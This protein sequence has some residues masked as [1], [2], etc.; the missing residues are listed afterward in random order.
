LSEKK[1]VLKAAGLVGLI[2]LVSRCTGLIRDM[3][4]GFKLSA[5]AISDTFWIAFELPNMVR[6]VM[7]EGALSSFLV[8]LFT[9]RRKKS[10]AEG[11]LFFNRVAN[12][13]LVL[14]LALTLFGGV[15]A[16]EAF[17]VFGAW[18]EVWRDKAEA[19]EVE[20]VQPPPSSSDAAANAPAAAPDEKPVLTTEEKIELGTRL[21][22]LMFP[23]VIGLT[24]ASVMMGAC[25]TLGRFATASLGSVMLNLTM[26]AAVAVAIIRGTDLERTT[27]WLC[28]AVLAGAVLRVLLMAPTLWRAG[29]RWRPVL[30]LS[31]PELRKLLKMMGLGL[32]GLSISQINILVGNFFAFYLGDGIKTYLV[33]ANRLV[34]F[35]MALTATAVATAMLPQLSRYIVGG[36]TGELREMMGFTKRVEII[37]MMPAMF[38]LAILGLPIMELLFQH[39]EWTA[40]ASHGAYL[41]LAFYAPALIPLGWIRLLIP[42]CYARKDLI[43]PLKA[44]LVSMVANVILNWFFVFHTPMAQSGLALAFTLASFIQYGWLAWM[45]RADLARRPGEELRIGETVWKSGLA[46]AVSCAVGGVIYFGS[47]RWILAPTNTL[48]RL[49]LFVPSMAAVVLL[50]FALIRQLRAPDFAWVSEQVLNR[51]RRG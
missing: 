1:T 24:L 9:E 10:E 45:M 3:V 48:S 20:L 49:A 25:H 32:L 14:A 46:A 39:G 51:L 28:W 31:D 17:L 50:Y 29:W 30:T 11:W 6:R 41:A 44:G 37:L 34:Q 8:P 23:F 13:T 18:G 26:I 36:Q 7:G 33:Y 40:E 42:L 43:T 19:A 12:F 5:G 22:R 35:P 27:I 16:R 47:A 38:G 2:T 15:F 4:L 21:T